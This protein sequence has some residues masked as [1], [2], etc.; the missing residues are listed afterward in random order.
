MNIKLITSACVA[1]ASSIGYADTP[2]YKIQL[3]PSMVLAGYANVQVDRAISETVSV[4][5][6]LWHLDD[7]SWSNY[8]GSETSFGVRVEWFE[9]DVFAS[10]WHSNAM[11]K[12][13]LENADYARTRFKL[14]QT[15][16]WVPQ[17]FLINLGIGVQ[18]ISESEQAQRD[19]YEY[20]SWMLP[21]WEFSIGRAF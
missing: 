3:D 14:T 20:Q 5:G 16:Q 8:D 4:G 13:D 18:F 7:N 6:M 2:K 17:D 11:V 19:L 12:V 9:N 15:Y 1:L 10:G 21:A